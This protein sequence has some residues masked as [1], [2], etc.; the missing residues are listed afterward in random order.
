M[1]L[2]NDPHIFVQ[3]TI[4]ECIDWNF[5]LT[6]VIGIIAVI[7]SGFFSSRKGREYQEKIIQLGCT[8]CPLDCIHT[9]H[10]PNLIQSSSS[11]T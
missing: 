7:Y 11:K 1:H 9:A 4:Q 6:I 5:S 10:S 3:A 2:Q 8:I